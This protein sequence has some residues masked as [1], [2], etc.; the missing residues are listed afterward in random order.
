MFKSERSLLL[1]KPIEQKNQHIKHQTNKPFDLADNN[2]I[3][4]IFE[5]LNKLLRHHLMQY[6][7]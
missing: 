6:K 2:L 1:I 3:R 7:V 4:D 5:P